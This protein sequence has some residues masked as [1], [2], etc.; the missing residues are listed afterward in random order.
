MESIV[1]RVFQ[2]DAAQCCEACVFGRGEHAA[3]CR[4]ITLDCPL[5]AGTR[6]RFDR[7][8]DPSRERAACA[9]CGREFALRCPDPITVEI[10]GGV[11]FGL[12]P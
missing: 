4:F 10:V 3:W 1:S 11:G 7:V 8:A 2:P 9:V 5:C 12:A 6:L